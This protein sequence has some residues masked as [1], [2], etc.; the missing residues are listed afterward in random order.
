MFLGYDLKSAEPIGKPS[1]SMCPEPV[2]FFTIGSV[3]NRHIIFGGPSAAVIDV[4]RWPPQFAYG[5]GFTSCGELPQMRI[6]EIVGE[7]A[8]R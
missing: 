6:V 8:K 1:K 5:K 7:C 4:K 2:V 3:R